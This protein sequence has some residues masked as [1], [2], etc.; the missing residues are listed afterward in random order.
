L[1]PEDVK[2]TVTIEIPTKIIWAIDKEAQS[3]K[4]TRER[5]IEEL[6]EFIYLG[7]IENVETNSLREDSEQVP[8]EA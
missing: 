1:K 6:I 4:I 2:Q 3:G 7:A 5:S 8:D